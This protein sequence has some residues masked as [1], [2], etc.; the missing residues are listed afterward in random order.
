MTKKA[1]C[2]NWS[3][4]RITKARLDTIRKYIDGDV[5]VYDDFIT[6]AVYGYVIQK[7]DDED[8]KGE[9]VDVEDASCWGFFGFDSIKEDGE[10][11]VQ[12]K[13]II[14]YIVKTEEKEAFRASLPENNPA[15]TTLGLEGIS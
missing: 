3:W 1:A 6:G 2:D 14:D 13:S 5:K 15:Q 7:E 12:A 11:V 8:D 9:M 10:A 4:K